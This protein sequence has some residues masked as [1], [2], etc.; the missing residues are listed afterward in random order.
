MQAQQGLK[1][2]QAAVRS[3]FRYEIHLKTLVV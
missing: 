2:Q 1:S 3:T